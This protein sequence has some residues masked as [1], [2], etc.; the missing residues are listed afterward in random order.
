MITYPF[1]LFAVS[2]GCV[3]RSASFYGKVLFKSTA[4]LAVLVFLA[5]YPISERL[6]GRPSEP[7]ARSAKRLSLL[8]LEITLP[9]TTTTL[10][11]T[12]ICQQ[13]DNGA[14]LR[15]SLTIACDDSP[16]RR[17]WVVFSAVTLIVYMIGVPTLI[18]TVMFQYRHAIQELGVK[19][20]QHNEQR[21]RTSLTAN[22]LVKSKQARSSF[23]SL[24]WEMR[25][26]L[27]KFEKFRPKAWF[28][29]VLLLL[30]RLLQ[31]SAVTF[32]QSQLAQAAIVC[33]ITL[34][35]ILLH[36]ELSPM[37]RPS[38]NHVALMAQVLRWL[39]SV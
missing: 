25:W 16:R 1:C 13:F 11:Q 27:S 7:A 39:S 36:S 24:H 22:E 23:V 26:L 6:R 10:I 12:F 19:L 21:G 34:V 38:D 33:F 18:F 9:S 31:T 32:V 37:R 8:L 5:C 17:L 2:L 30:L 15:E 29:G 14:F 20:Q 4:P 35:S 28:T 3:F